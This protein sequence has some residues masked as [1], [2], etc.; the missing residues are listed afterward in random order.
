MSKIGKQP[1]TIEKNVTV[2]IDNQKV[3]VKGPKGELQYE[4]PHELAV[5]LVE[6]E[7]LVS[8]NIETK[9]AQALWGLWRSLIAN[10]VEGTMNGFEKKLELVG[11]GYRGAMKGKDLE[12]QLGFSHPVLYTAPE[13]ITLGIDGQIISVTGPDKQL[14]GQIASEIRAFRQPEP[15]KGKGIKYIDEII[16]RKAGKAAKAVG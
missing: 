6:G 14:V 13:G 12:L 1:I 8:K 3:S 15:Y 7:V 16:R 11:V 4:L 10:A 9:E 2:T 5:E